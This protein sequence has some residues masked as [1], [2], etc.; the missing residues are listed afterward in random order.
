MWPSDAILRHRSCTKLLQVTAWRL[1]N[2]WKQLSERYHHLHSRMRLKTLSAKWGL[3]MYCSG[4]QYVSIK[5]THISVMNTTDTQARK[6]R[7]GD[8]PGRWGFEACLQRLQWRSK[9]PQWRLFRFCGYVS[10][11]FLGKRRRTSLMISLHCFRLYGWA[12][13]LSATLFEKESTPRKRMCRSVSH[14]SVSTNPSTRVW[15]TVSPF[16]RNLFALLHLMILL[17]SPFRCVHFCSEWCIVRC[18]TGALW[19]LWNRSIRFA[20]YWDMRYKYKA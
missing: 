12:P 18:G 13:T 19:D 7:Q 2:P 16:V 14:R 17:N 6:G 4:P 3:Y 10:W 9:Q 8:S 5:S 15:C 20:I 1:M 11:A